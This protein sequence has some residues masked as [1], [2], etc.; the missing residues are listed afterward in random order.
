M[1]VVKVQFVNFSVRRGSLAFST[2]SDPVSFRQPILDDLRQSD[3]TQKNSQENRPI[4]SRESAEGKRMRKRGKGHGNADGHDPETGQDER[5]TGPA[6]NERNAVRPN[7][8]DDQC[9]S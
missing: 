5:P 2:L 9:L 6:L 1:R 3:V 4:Q 8:M 7:D